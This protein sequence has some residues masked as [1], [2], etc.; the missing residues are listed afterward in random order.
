MSN[1]KYFVVV[2]R[3][4][5]SGF[6]EKMDMDKVWRSNVQEDGW[7]NQDVTGQYGSIRGEYDTLGEAQEELATYLR[8]DSVEKGTYCY[9]HNPM[10]GRWY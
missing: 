3:A 5:H 4:E 2:N 1:Y 6:I 7:T 9:T 10:A 8:C